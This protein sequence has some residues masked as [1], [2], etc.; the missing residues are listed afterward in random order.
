[1]TEQQDNDDDSR[2]LTAAD[3]K[4]RWKKR[5]AELREGDKA[6][7]RLADSLA[8]CRGGYHCDLIECPKCERRKRKAQEQVPAS[9]AKN[10]SGRFRIWLIRVKAIQVVGERRPLNDHKVRAIAASMALMGLETPISVREERHKIILVSGWHRL[11]AAKLLKWREIPCVLMRPYE[12][13]ARIW[14]KVENFYRAELTVLERAEIVEEL[15]ELAWLKVVQDAPPGGQQPKDKGINK[16]ARLLGLTKDEIR[17]SRQIAGISAKAKAKVRKLGLDDNQRALLAI[18]GQPTPKAQLCVITEIVER[19]RA[20]RDRNASAAVADKKTTAEINALDADIRQKEGALDR[21]KGDL[22]ASRKRRQELDDKLAVHG[23]VADR[24]PPSQAASPTTP[25]DDDVA[26]EAVV[27]A[28]ETEGLKAELA[29]ATERVRCLEQELENAR[30]L[31]SRAQEIE[32]SVKAPCLD[33]P[34]FLD[35]RLVSAEDQ[36][37]FDEIKAAWDSHVHP[38]LQRASAVIRERFNGALRAYLASSSSAA[39]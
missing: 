6:D 12:I 28:A 17:R 25:A 27:P 2:V 11:E 35:R 22:A 32:T 31:A 13:D 29:V 39:G 36:L 37:A 23:E 4:Q 20:A 26:V 24:G 14:Q 7:R 19:K 34:P 9:V 3:A 10:L 38:L 8:Q 1:M 16:T 33:I 5:I 18:A 30:A 15:R 21:L